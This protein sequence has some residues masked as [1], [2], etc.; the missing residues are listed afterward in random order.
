MLATFLLAMQVQA[1]TVSTARKDASAPLAPSSAVDAASATRARATRAAKAPLIDGRDD[2]AI[3]REAQPITSFREFDPVE[4]GE[5]SLPT[6]AKIAFDDKYFYVFVR[7]FDPHPD[8]IRAF[9]SRRDVRTAS[10]QIKVLIDSYNDKRSGYEFAVNPAGVKRD[11]SMSSDGNEDDSWDGVWDVATRIDEKGWTAEFRIPFG[12]MRFAKSAS[13]AFGF[14]IWRDIARTNVRVGWPV[15]RRS[16]T[17]LVSQLGEVSGIDGIETPRRLE[18]TPYTVAKDLTSNR[19]DGSAGRSQQLTGGLDVKYGLTSNLTLDATVN[20]DFGQVEA[21]PSVLNLTAFEQFYQ[22]RRPFFVEGAG[23][24]NFNLNCNDGNCSGLFYSRRIGRSPQLGGLYG[25]AGTKQNTNIVGAAKLTG[26]LANGL[27]VGFLDAATERVSGPGNETVEPRTNYLVGRLQQDLNNGNSGIGLMATATNRALDLW[28]RDYLRS[29]GY[30]LGLDA[31]HRLSGN[32]YELSGYVAGSDVEGSPAAITATQRNSVHF[33]QRPD[34]HLAVDSTRTSLSGYTAQFA[35]SKVGGERVRFNTNYQRTSAGFEANDA[36]F[37]SRADQQSLGNWL[38]LA[39]IKPTSWYRSVRVNFNQWNQWT[40]A[41]LPTER[42]GNFNAHAQFTNQ[43]NGHLGFNLNNVG[44]TYDDRSS[45]GGPA[46]PQ[47]F[48]YSGWGG[49]ETDQRKWLAVNFFFNGRF[50]DASGTWAYA[51]DPGVTMRVS[52]R[53]QAHVGVSYFRQLDDAQWNGNFTDTN[54]DTHYT[55]ARLNQ[56]V[57][58]LTTRIDFT[59]TPTLT[60]QLY[61]APFITSGSFS[62]WR[63]IS[64]TPRAETYASRFKPYTTQG[65]PG[66]FNFKQFR[67][68]AVVRWEYRPGSTLFLVWSQGREQDGV[69]PGTYDFRRDAGELFRVRPNNTFLIKTSYWFSL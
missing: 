67:S 7:A 5:P 61:A 15:Y 68:N 46:L 27:S 19:A 51:F 30:T 13:Q 6:E 45:R 16:K 44:R 1:T 48:G 63:E 36:G 17:G 58:S 56:T 10:D 64:A 22:E 34:A 29:A 33:Y 4:D 35:F 62:N 69:N 26:R 50:K 60:L 11:Y 65:D 9:L 18:I 53:L 28:S 32:R 31:R 14:G 24:F 47:L 54:G 23:I 2:D 40:T 25:D 38:Q 12:Q 57:T 41:G 43:W 37:L 21:D 39:W 52:S 49:F 66:G 8:S 42:G 59:A 55:F 20:P 3:W